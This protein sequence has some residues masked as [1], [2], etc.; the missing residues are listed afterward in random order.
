MNK[1]SGVLMV[2]LAVC[3]GA[4]ENAQ[5]KNWNT[6]KSDT[7]AKKNVSIKQIMQA[8]SKKGFKFHERNVKHEEAFQILEYEGRPP[9]KI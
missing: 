9:A 2:E 7:N 6:G 5:G 3:I 1:V 4:G 8:D